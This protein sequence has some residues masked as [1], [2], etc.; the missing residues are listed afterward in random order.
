[1]DL[2]FNDIRQQSQNQFVNNGWLTIYKCIGGYKKEENGTIFCCIGYKGK[3]SNILSNHSWEL[4]STDYQ[5]GFVFS[6]KNGEKVVEYFRISESS[7]EPFLFKIRGLNERPSYFEISEEFRLYH[8][9]YEIYRSPN[10][11]DY[12]YT[13]GNGDEEIVIKIRDKEVVVKLKFVK[14]YISARDMVFIIYYDIMRFSSK[15][16]EEIGVVEEQHTTQTDNESFLIGARPYTMWPIPDCQTQ[17]WI[18]GKV[19]ISPIPNYKPKLFRSMDEDSDKYAEFIIGYDGE[20]KLKKFTCDPSKLKN[21]FGDNANAPYDLT[22]IYFSRQVLKK[23]YDNPSQYTVNDGSV[24]RGN[25]WSLDID[26]NN[27]DYVS[28][29][30]CD[31]GRLHYK[32]QIHWQHYEIAEGKGL[33]RTAYERAIL[34]NWSSP[35]NPELVFKQKYKI[36]T[37]IWEEKYGWPLF[38]PLIKSDEHY[39]NSFHLLTVSNN[40]KEFDEQ[41]LS[42][43]K[44]IIDSL[45]EKEL[46]KSIEVEEGDKGIKKLSKWLQFHGVNVPAMIDFLINLQSLRSTTVAHRRSENNKLLKKANEYFGIDKKPLDEVLSDITV[47]CIGMFYAMAQYVLEIDLDTAD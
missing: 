11:K 33:S 42:I 36:F 28:V 34:G 31:L 5:P 12:L 29:F 13:N 43:T 35:R 7:V 38:K 3:V 30:L 16:M 6:Y 25:L 15:T 1:M 24:T 27:K 20:G 19:I 9:L 17:V 10:D 41:I 46:S 14:D 40:E 26:N 32:E 18:T 23:Y 39:L 2:K 8:N 37:K 21:A 44:I 22:P 4:H 45:N 47:K